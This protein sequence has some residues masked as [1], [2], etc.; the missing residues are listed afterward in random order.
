VEKT[1]VSLEEFARWA[2]L[3]ENADRAYELIHGEV[4]EVTPART[5]HSL[6]EHLLAVAVHVY[7]RQ[8]DLPCY[9]SGGDAAYAILGNVLAPDFAYKPTRMSDLYPD[10]ERPM[11]AVEIISPTEKA[12]AI[13][14]KREIYRQAGILYWEMYPNT[15]S[16]DIYAPGEPMRTVDIDGTVDGGSVLPGFT[17][18]L[19]E[20]FAK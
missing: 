3:P 15:Q 6:L 19:R 1:S 2:E 13:R 7:C 9:T 18:P 8:H 12:R 5:S 11:W 20:L 10:P 17:L 14:N 4:I 16:V